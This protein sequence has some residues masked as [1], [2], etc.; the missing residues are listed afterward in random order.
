MGSHI[1]ESLLEKGYRVILLKRSHSDLSKIR[2][3]INHPSLDLYDIDIV[4]LEPAFQNPI[5]VIIHT[6]VSY[7]R[8]G[9]S[10]VSDLLDANLLFPVK[11]AELGIKYGVKGFVNTD[12]FF[13]KETYSSYGYMEQYSALK[14]DLAY[15][16]KSF[17]DKISVVNMRLEHM[18][19]E[20]DAPSKFVMHIF[21]QLVGNTDRIDLS[22]GG[23]KRDF[24]YVKDVASAF[25]AVTSDLIGQPGVGYKTFEVGTGKSHE[26]RFFVDE[27]KR[28]MRSDSVL[29]YGAFP[30]RE[31]EIMDSHADITGLTLLGW[32]TRYDL[33]Q[34]ITHIL[35]SYL[36]G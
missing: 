24:V 5:Q 29:N 12:S 26:I 14:R 7:G 33:Q 9:S 8:A 25:L 11:L 31:N 23:Q 35:E 2:H 19:G 20:R 4:G 6:A 34:G 21:H 3:L 10:T 22:P 16:L 28:I 30:Y 15:W 18:Y 13:T 17:S 36:K 27:M 32:T 1:A